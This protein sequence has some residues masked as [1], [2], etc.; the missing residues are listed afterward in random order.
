MPNHG[1]D[2]VSLSTRLSF[3][4]LVGSVELLPD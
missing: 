4:T 3:V 2:H 1:L